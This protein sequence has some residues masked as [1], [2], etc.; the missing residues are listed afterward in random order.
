MFLFC[1]AWSLVL[2][3]RKVYNDIFV[4]YLCRR[5]SSYHKVRLKSRNPEFPVH[6]YVSNSRD[7]HCRNSCQNEIS[8]PFLFFLLGLYWHIDFVLSHT[9]H[10]PVLLSVCFCPCPSICLNLSIFLSFSFYPSKFFLY[11]SL[12]LTQ[13]YSSLNV[14]VEKYNNCFLTLFVTGKSCGKDSP[15]KKDNDD[16]LWSN[17]EAQAAFLSPNIWDNKSLPYDTDLKVI[18]EN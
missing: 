15:E 5:I 3:L 4:S 11:H 9:L 16:L 2:L 8:F 7:S 18:Y 12:R 6:W 13:F 14:S 10:S 17:V 1:S